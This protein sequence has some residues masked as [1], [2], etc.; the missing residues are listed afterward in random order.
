MDKV[1][2]ETGHRGIKGV[3]LQD[4]TVTNDPKVVLEEVLN[5]FLRQHNTEDG[6]LSA[7]T[8]NLISHLPKLYN[9][10]QRRDMHRTPFTIREL[11]EVLY[12]LQPGKTP[13]VDRLPA[14]L[15]RRLPLN[16]KRHLA[17]RLWDIA[18]R[19]T[20][21]PP[22]WANL[23]HPLYKKGDWANPDNWRP[24]V[25]ATTEAKPIPMLIL[26][27]AAPAVHRAVPPTMWG[28]IPGRSPL[29]AI[30]LQDTVVDMDPISLII[31]SLDVKGA[32]P[33]TPHR[34]LRAVLEHMGLPF[35][36]FLQAYLA[37]RMYAK[38]TD[39]GT[40]PWVHHASGVPQGGAEGPFLFLQVSL[41]LAFYIRRT[42][43]DMAPY[44]LQITLLAFADDM[45]VVTAT[46]RQPLRSTPDP[47]R[48]TKVLH[49]VTIYLEG[50]Q[51]LIH[52]DKSATM[53]HNAPPPPLCPGDLPM[54][55]VHTATDLG[56]Q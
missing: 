48:A 42:Y 20:N 28:A 35:Q 36:G 6:E 33:N 10:T 23:V 41:P 49:V 43:P 8:E 9:P 51:L 38:K 50:N 32:F 30:F 55:P 44:P 31:T 22:D 25:C 29:E 16:L 12:K 34:L 21:V 45:A 40:T 52:N 3:H 5:S 4:G 18:T 26:K 13:G 24:I 46:A 1:F 27:R 54:H 39:L 37:T 47:A 56:V 11:D 2:R 17:A 7:Y 53:V 14:E 15:Y 19:K